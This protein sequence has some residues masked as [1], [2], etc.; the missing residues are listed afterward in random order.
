[1]IVAIR[2][3]A[4]AVTIQFTE[5][6][7]EGVPISDI[8]KLYVLY[9]ENQDLLRRANE[10][11]ALRMAG[12]TTSANASEMPTRDHSSMSWLKA[13]LQPMRLRAAIWLQ[14]S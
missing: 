4:Q 12:K 9:S 13:A 2:S 6:Q 8:V 11:S 14:L 3:R 10:L 5:R 7:E 1:V